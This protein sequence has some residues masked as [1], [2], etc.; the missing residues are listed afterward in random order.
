MNT[1]SLVDFVVKIDESNEHDIYQFIRK[2]LPQNA[3]GKI[4]SITAR[5]DMREKKGKKP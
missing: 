5:I 1:N 2:S 3:K 4:V